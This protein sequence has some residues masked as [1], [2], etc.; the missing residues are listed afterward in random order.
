MLQGDVFWLSVIVK[1]WCIQT[2][3]KPHVHRE[4]PPETSPRIISEIKARKLSIACFVVVS[5]SINKTCTIRCGENYETW[6]MIYGYIFFLVLSCVEY[7]EI[8]FFTILRRL[9][10]W[11]LSWKFSFF[12][13][14]ELLADKTHKLNIF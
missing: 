3:V 10:G 9:A 6:K 13:V 4:R 7:G 12:G 2:K 11:N 8:F 5:S 14:F 1:L